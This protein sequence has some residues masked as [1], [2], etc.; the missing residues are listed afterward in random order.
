M[1]KPYYSYESG[2]HRVMADDEVGRYTIADCMDEA[3]ARKVAKLL[4]YEDIDEI[5]KSHDWEQSE[6]VRLGERVKELE[7]VIRRVASQL[8]PEIYPITIDIL[9]KALAGKEPANCKECDGKGWNYIGYG[10]PPEQ[11]LCADCHGTGKES[12]SG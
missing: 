10:L 3:T 4:S 1:N 11:E 2:G 5:L 8:N 9:Y 6:A 7:D 12:S